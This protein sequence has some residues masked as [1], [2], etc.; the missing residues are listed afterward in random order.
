M[1]IYPDRCIRGIPDNSFLTDDGSIG[2]HLFYFFDKHNRDDGWVEQSINWEDDDTVIEFSLQQKKV[3]GSLQFKAGIVLIP[4]EEVDRLN[5]L[6]TVKGLISYER[7]PLEDNS[8]HG[9]ILLKSSLP[10]PTMKKIAAGLAL[11]VSDIINR[12]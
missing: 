2:T 5:N 9:N 3:D 8:Y 7:R 11:A 12:K 6:P 4:R 1:C 10:R